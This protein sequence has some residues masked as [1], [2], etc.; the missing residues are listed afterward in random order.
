M[1][2]READQSGWVPPTPTKTCPCCGFQ[3]SNGIDTFDICEICSWEA[4]AVQSLDPRYPVGPNGINLEQARRNYLEFGA[5][6]RQSLP[7][8]RPPLESEVPSLAV[9]K[10]PMDLA[11]LREEVD[12][13]LF[14][15]REHERQ[16]DARIAEGRWPEV[17]IARIHRQREH[18]RTLH[19]TYGGLN[20]ELLWI[21]VHHD[22]MRIRELE[23]KYAPH[24][25]VSQVEGILP[26]LQGTRSSRDVRHLLRQEFLRWF[27]EPVVGE[28]DQFT[29]LA[30][31]VWAALGRNP[32]EGGIENVEVLREVI[33]PSG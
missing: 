18:E 26:Q 21:F 3:S 13:F 7:H 28:E 19:H 1:S 12:Y 23:N 32:L 25:Y 27:V 9:E 2:N 10:Q 31:D 30:E 15:E 8:V 20:A 24:T 22:P 14:A 29:R 6:D 16:R 11:Q 5:K 17:A 33:E 4:D